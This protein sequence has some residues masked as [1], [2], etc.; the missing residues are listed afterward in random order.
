MARKQLPLQI[1]PGAPGSGRSRKTAAD[2]RDAL[3]AAL[4]AACC[5]L[6]REATTGETTTARLVLGRLRDL[7]AGGTDGTVH[8]S[9]T[10]PPLPSPR[11]FADY[12]DDLAAMLRESGQRRDRSGTLAPGDVPA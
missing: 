1:V 11:R 10:G 5:A 4:R 2:E 3:E 8:P 9:M 12:L 7:D 6:L